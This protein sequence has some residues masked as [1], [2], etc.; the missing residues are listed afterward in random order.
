MVQRIQLTACLR[1]VEEEEGLALVVADL[2]GLR[3]LVLDRFLPSRA[4]LSTTLPVVLDVF[5]LAIAAG[6]SVR[7]ATTIQ[8]LVTTSSM[9]ALAG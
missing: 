5:W 3:L 6:L 4:V 7:R 1:V 2:E 8:S 9:A